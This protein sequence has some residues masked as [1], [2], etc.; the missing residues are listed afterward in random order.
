[1]KSVAR[2]LLSW[3]LLTRLKLPVYLLCMYDRHLLTSTS[4]GWR[5]LKRGSKLDTQLPVHG[6]LKHT[7]SS[8]MESRARIKCITALLRACTIYAVQERVISGLLDYNGEGREYSLR[9]CFPPAHTTLCAT[10]N[11]YEPAKDSASNLT[12]D[13][14]YPIV[15]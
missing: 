1:M 14:M 9:S 7:H 8:A 11:L 5:F 15:I 2:I 13:S 4:I 10:P 3:Y 6:K 12:I